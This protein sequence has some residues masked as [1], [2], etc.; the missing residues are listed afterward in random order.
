MAGI[1]PGGVS[2][3]PCLFS[4][5]CIFSPEGIFNFHFVILASSFWAGGRVSE[6]E[7]GTGDRSPTS[8]PEWTIFLPVAPWYS[9]H[10]GE[11]TSPR[12][13]WS[14]APW[15]VWHSCVCMLW[16]VPSWWQAWTAASPAEAPACLSL[17]CVQGNTTFAVICVGK[18][19]HAWEKTH[20]SEHS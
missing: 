19:Q 2:S 5:A 7:E 18:L 12:L 15:L 17:W 9:P 1:H 8:F 6:A 13:I 11:L 4:H 16:L 3:L 14:R 20:E 10:S